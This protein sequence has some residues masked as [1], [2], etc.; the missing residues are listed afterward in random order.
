MTECHCRDR[1]DPQFP[2]EIHG[3]V[4]ARE[5]TRIELLEKRVTELERPSAALLEADK[6]YTNAIG[7]WLKGQ[8][9]LETALARAET[10]EAGLKYAVGQLG[11]TR[12]E[13]NTGAGRIRKT[14][15][16]LAERDRML[17][18]AYLDALLEVNPGHEVPLDAWLADLSARAKEGSS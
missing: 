5:T 4:F 11:I 15:A 17:E 18:L 10:A 8:G 13:L 3:Y 16:A 9:E 2:C 14:E 1:V 7:L 12:A 6:G